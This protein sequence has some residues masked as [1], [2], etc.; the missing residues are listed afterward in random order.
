M[1]TISIEIHLECE[2]MH[3]M[4]HATEYRDGI[5][6]FH[7]PK[8]ISVG[9]A[10]VVVRLVVNQQHEDRIC[11]VMKTAS[12]TIYDAELLET[13]VS[14]LVESVNWQHGFRLYA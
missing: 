13:A 12:A 3:I 11:D 10:G 7:L 1:D 5:W 8:L 9:Q 2:Q 6:D 14:T 4:V